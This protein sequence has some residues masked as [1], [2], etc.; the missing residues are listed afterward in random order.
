MALL[1]ASFYCL[2]ANITSSSLS[3]ALVFLAMDFHP[4]VAQADLTHL[5]AVRYPILVLSV[6]LTKILAGQRLDVGLC[7]HLVGSSL[8]RVRSPTHYPLQSGDA[9]GVLR[10][11]SQSHLF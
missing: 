7:Q 6:P 10:L 8:E 4:P 11:D 5:I 3:S 1:S 2:I 9:H